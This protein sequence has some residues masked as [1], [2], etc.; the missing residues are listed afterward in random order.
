MKLN[1]IICYKDLDYDII[2][3]QNKTINFL[4]SEFCQKDLSYSWC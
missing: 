1:G 3:Q 2:Q 4:K